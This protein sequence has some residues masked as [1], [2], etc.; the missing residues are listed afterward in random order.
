[1]LRNFFYS[2]NPIA[3]GDHFGVKEDVWRKE[4]VISESKDYLDLKAAVT[5]FIVTL[6][7]G[8]NY[9]AIK[10]SNR[11]ISPVFA[12]TLRSAIATICGVI[13]CIKKK[14]ALC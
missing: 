11:G 1:V 4:M 7:W 10:Y 6:L 9:A 13:Y 3:K 14:E 2:T 8:L 12:C 5:L